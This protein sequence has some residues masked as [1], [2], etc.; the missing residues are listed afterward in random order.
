LK[1]DF[2]KIIGSLIQAFLAISTWV[3]ILVA[4]WNDKEPPAIIFGAGA[5]LL[6]KYGLEKGAAVVAKTRA[7]ARPVSPAPVASTGQNPE[8]KA[9]VQSDPAA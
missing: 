3:F 5:A 6:A 1:E 4:Y 9:E 2:N 7:P 8:K